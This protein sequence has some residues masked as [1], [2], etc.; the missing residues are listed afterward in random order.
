MLPPDKLEFWIE[1]TGIGMPSNQLEVIFERFRQVELSN[2]R[3]YGGTGLGLTI[4][5]SL[6]QMMGGAINVESVE[7]EGS[8][9]RFTIAYLPVEAAD[10]PVFAEIR[11]E[12]PIEDQYFPGASILVVEPE[13]ICLKYYEKIL[14]YNGATTIF[15]QNVEQW[16]EMMN[17]E[18]HIDMV[19]V[20][21]R[22]FQNE[23][24]ETYK[25]IKSVRAGLPMIMITP[26]RNDYFN[27]II[28][29]MQ[30]TR[31]LEGRPDYQTLCEE[32]L[33]IM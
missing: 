30:C 21:A 29:N 10:E 1:D 28:N 31:V 19:L 7:D 3:K 12:K 22:V 32:L 17:Q 33:R 15:A 9:F 11:T 2:H 5:R 25:E 18:K 14:T 20:D 23:D 8:T 16:I 4:S 24:T 13:V 6:V 27:R 26:E